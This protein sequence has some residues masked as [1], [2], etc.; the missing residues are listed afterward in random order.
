MRGEKY[1]FSVVKHADPGGERKS[2]KDVGADRKAV[3]RRAVLTASNWYE[4]AA[5]SIKAA[6]GSKVED[7]D[8]MIHSSATPASAAVRPGKLRPR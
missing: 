3:K 2:S 7:E 1:Y 5:S 8:P 6:Q 4:R